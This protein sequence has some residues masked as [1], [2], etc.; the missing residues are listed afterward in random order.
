MAVRDGIANA[1]QLATAQQKKNIHANTAS[2]IPRA[3]KIQKDQSEDDEEPLLQPQ[4][5]RKISTST[6][7]VEDTSVMVCHIHSQHQDQISDDYHLGGILR[8]TTPRPH[9]PPLHRHPPIPSPRHPHRPP[10]PKPS[11]RDTLNPPTTRHRPKPL[12]PPPLLPPNLAQSP[13][14]FIQPNILLHHSLQQS[15]YKRRREGKARA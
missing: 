9:R 4:H 2:K 8:R 3:S 5:H 6:P 12:R 14:D 15:T 7:Y 11:Q 13:H 10:H 1:K